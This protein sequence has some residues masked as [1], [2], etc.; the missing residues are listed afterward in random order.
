MRF[1]PE[2]R[3]APRRDSSF[4]LHLCRIDDLPPFDRI[5]TQEFGEGVEWFRQRLHRKRLQIFFLKFGIADYFPR[6]RH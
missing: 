1:F 2:R 3:F 6:R 5:L 4:D